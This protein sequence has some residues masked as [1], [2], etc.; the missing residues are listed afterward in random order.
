MVYA[1]AK[2]RRSKTCLVPWV[3]TRNV[4]CLDASVANLAFSEGFLSQH[5][6][7]LETKRVSDWTNDSMCTPIYYNDLTPTG[8]TPKR[9]HRGRDLLP[10]LP[11][12]TQ[13]PLR[14]VTST[15]EPSTDR[16]ARRWEGGLVRGSLVP[17]GGRRPQT[18]PGKLGPLG[19]KSVITQ[20]VVG[21]VKR[22]TPGGCREGSRKSVPCV[23]MK[24][25][26]TEKRVGGAIEASPWKRIGV[27][28]GASR[29]CHRS[30]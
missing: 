3:P 5:T 8:G 13:Y 19:S 2:K 20:G 9:H 11:A 22:Y 4:A 12:T 7:A 24:R 25:G 26:A 30:E 21:G 1:N 14:G 6:V 18:K 17:P 27:A 15:R 29:C 10:K 23:S 28:I 16:K